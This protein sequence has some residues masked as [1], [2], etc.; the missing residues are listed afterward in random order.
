MKKVNCFLLMAFTALISVSFGVKP[1][2]DIHWMSMEEM[3]AAYAKNPKPILIDLYT[4]WCGWCKHMDKTTYKTDKVVEYINKNYYAVKYN[5]E[6]KDDVL[7]NN[8]TYKF[9]S[10]YNTN[11]LAMFLSFGEL[12]YPTTIFLPTL[13]AR[14]A[15]LAGFMKPKEMEAPLKYF[16]ER[17]NEQVSFVDFNKGLKKEW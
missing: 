12:Q 17:Q 1:A 2:E 6:S 11:D 4:D 15:P 5:A 13:D 9:N 7:F 3:Q 8:K 14:P 16:A 10:K